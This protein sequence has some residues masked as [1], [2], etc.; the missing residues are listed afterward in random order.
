[1]HENRNGTPYGSMV[2]V[3][4]SNLWALAQKMDPSLNWNHQPQDVRD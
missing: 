1:V 4:H 2:V 3:L